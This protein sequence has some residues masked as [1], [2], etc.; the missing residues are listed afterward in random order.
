M[1][2]F[3]L[4]LLLGLLL[5]LLS[6]C[7][8]ETAPIEGQAA[9][10]SQAN[11]QAS[12]SS[13]P[14]PVE[15]ATAQEVSQQEMNDYC[16]A[17][18]AN[19]EKLIET[20]KPEKAA[21]ELQA[22]GLVGDVISR[23]PWEKV[24]VDAVQF[25]GSIH[26]LN[27]CVGCHGGVQSPDKETAH[28]GLVV[29]PSKDAQALCG[30]CH[31]DIVSYNTSSL[32]ANQTGF[33]TVMNA[34]SAPR[35]H[36]G[37]K[38]A[39]DGNC[40]SCHTTCGECHV[41]QPAMAGGGF[42]NGHLFSRTPSMTANCAVC[43][44]SR[45]GNEYLGKNDGQPADVHFEQGGMDCM[46][47]HNAHEIHGQ[48]D[49]CSSCHPG[50]QNSAVQP[51][52]HRYGGIQSPR[53]ESCHAN[54]SAGQDEILMHQMHGSNL[55]CQV[56]HSVAY[57]NCDGCHVTGKDPAGKPIYELESVYSMFLIG[58][59]PMQSY[60]RPYRYVPV[61]HVPVTRDIFDLF[62][63]NLLPNFDQVETWKY[64]TPHNI[65]RRTPQTESC[66]ACHGNPAVFLT[67]DKIAPDELEANRKVIVDSPPPPITS[68]DQ[69]P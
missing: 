27:G 64:T 67:A 59:N 14:V 30:K 7:A 18:H 6:A 26:G 36:A 24:W 4:L 45:V 51:P 54:I 61:R 42:V 63:A 43:H 65:Q 33:Y 50:P 47:C 12:E 19:Q 13:E 53:C 38:A 29:N 31:P 58:R 60:E 15:L 11:S 32:H 68:R 1:L 46:Q 56:C 28:A 49:D 66:N 2:K 41:S 17:C 8:G 16:L 3:K 10:P 48:P 21:G 35:S 23:E 69:L 52:D 25:P 40:T 22:A 5:V 44:S 57:T 20:A 62:G 34:R 9:K 39:I 37:L 55:S